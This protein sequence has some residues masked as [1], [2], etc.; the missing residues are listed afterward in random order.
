M[1]AVATSAG[2]C[3]LGGI[4]N[5]SSVYPIART[6]RLLSGS[7]ATI[8]G[9]RSPPCKSD[10]REST[11]RPLSVFLPPWHGKQSVA[12]TGRILV[13]KNVSDDSSARAEPA[14]TRMARREYADSRSI[15][16]TPV[17]RD[18]TSSAM[19]ANSAPFGG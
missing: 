16:S 1:N 13:S 7:P 8:A 18:R 10:S 14:R 3:R 19:I 9:P 12:R 2:R 4:F 6:S 17:G 15:A 11:L 5:S